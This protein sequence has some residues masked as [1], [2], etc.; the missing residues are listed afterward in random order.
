MLGG[1]RQML[2]ARWLHDNRL[3]WLRRISPLQI[4]EQAR[5]PYQQQN[6]CVQH[7]HLA[8]CW[9]VVEV[10]FALLFSVWLL[11]ASAVAAP[12]LTLEWGPSPDADVNNYRLYWGPGSGNYNGFVD[13]G[14]V[15]NT[16]FT[17]LVP[18][19]HYYF[20]VT[21]MNA[22]GAESDPSN[23]IDFL[24]PR[25]KPK[26][27]VQFRITQVLKPT[28]PPAVPWSG[29]AASACQLPAA[30]FTATSFLSAGSAPHFLMEEDGSAL[31]DAEGCAMTRPGSSKL[32]GTFSSAARS[33]TGVR[34]TT[35][36]AAS[37]NGCNPLGPGAKSIGASE[38]MDMSCGGGWRQ[39]APV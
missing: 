2:S 18:G 34:V 6:V 30:S 25:V 39:A 32:G 9:R 17:R 16:V 3:F 31:V 29:L 11:C 37:S 28:T 21:A 15:T 14:N 1:Q 22:E 20:V 36:L 10:V 12:S 4:G 8:G 19:G 24:I 5:S 35:R 33:A 13:L 23:E 27:P 7:R 26:P 38:R